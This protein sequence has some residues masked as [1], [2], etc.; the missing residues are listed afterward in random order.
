MKLISKIIATLL[1]VIP[2][3]AFAQEISDPPLPRSVPEMILFYSE[4]YEVSYDLIYSTVKC[5]TAGTFNPKIQSGVKYNFSDPKRNLVKGELERSYGLAQIHLPDH[6][7]I[8]IEQA[9]DPD[10]ALDFMA[11]NLSKGRTWMWYCIKK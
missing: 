11:S 3:F 9:I 4:K 7:H 1:V 5:E 6:P 10:F 8:S 2:L